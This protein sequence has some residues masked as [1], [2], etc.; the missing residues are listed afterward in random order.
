MNEKVYRVLE[1][2]KIKT[3]YYVTALA[4]SVFSFIKPF[5]KLK[6]IISRRFDL[7][8][9]IENPQK[10]GSAPAFYLSLCIASVGI[11]LKRAGRFF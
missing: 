8:H 1:Y 2:N 6:I 3:F 10:A 7:L 4:F 9:H 5:K 11:L